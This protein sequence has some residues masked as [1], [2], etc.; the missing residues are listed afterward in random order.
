[1]PPK[2]IEQGLWR[3]PKGFG[4]VR[5][6]REVPPWAGDPPVKSARQRLLLRSGRQMVYVHSTRTSIGAHGILL[7]E[8]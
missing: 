7:G 1:M 3:A 5:R 6:K 2:E 4:F 8:V